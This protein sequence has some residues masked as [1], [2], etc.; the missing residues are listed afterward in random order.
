M[1]NKKR[2]KIPKWPKITYKDTFLYLVGHE[3]STCY[4]IYT[5][6]ICVTRKEMMS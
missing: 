1:Q 4:N 3:Q 5:N 2:H 6:F